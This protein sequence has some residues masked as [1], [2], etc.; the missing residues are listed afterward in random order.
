MI[1]EIDHTEVRD[2]FRHLLREVLIKLRDGER[3]SWQ[4]KK[5]QF[6]LEGEGL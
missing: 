2:G 5:G 1:L 3:R 4:F 6:Y